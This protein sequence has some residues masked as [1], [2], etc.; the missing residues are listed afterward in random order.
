MTH[1]P[2]KR[3]GQN[4]LH[5]PGVIR[6]IVAS[7]APKPG[8]RLVEIGPGQGAITRELLFAVGTK[9]VIELDRD[10]VRPLVKLC[11]VP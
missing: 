6:Q 7:I 11:W 3:F 5:D 8:D 9:D 1:R 10:L 4:F 2:R